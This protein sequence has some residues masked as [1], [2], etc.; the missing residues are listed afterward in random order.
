MTQQQIAL[1]EL[2]LVGGM[3][4]ILFIAGILIK[5]LTER[6]NSRCTSKTVGKVIQ[7]SFMSDGRIA[8]VVEYES[9]G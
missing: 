5:V 2:A 9:G 8:T 3:G 7:Y 6:K 4:A 1:L